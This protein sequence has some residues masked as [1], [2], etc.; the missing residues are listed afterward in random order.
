MRT[1]LAKFQHDSR[2]TIGD[3]HKYLLLSAR[4]WGRGV[5]NGAK[6]VR[7]QAARDKIHLLRLAQLLS[8]WKECILQTCSIDISRNDTCRAAMRIGPCHIESKKTTL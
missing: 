4:G 2:K 7:N 3:A 1:K 6:D 5:G 8:H